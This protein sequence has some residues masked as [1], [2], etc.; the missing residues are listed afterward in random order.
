VID[1][2]IIKILKS[3]F[4]PHRSNKLTTGRRTKEIK[5]EKIKGNIMFDPNERIKIILHRLTIKYIVVFNLLS[6]M[7]RYYILCKCT[8]I[9]GVP[10][11]L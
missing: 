2:T 9:I 4:A 10:L 3:L 6:I 5:K 11:K 1:N 8:L 7:N